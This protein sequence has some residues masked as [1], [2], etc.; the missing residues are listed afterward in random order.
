MW[1]N[2]N[3]R[4]L[5]EAD[6]PQA[7]QQSDYS[8]APGFDVSQQTAYEGTTV[9][10]SEAVTSNTQATV[11]P[12]P[13]PVNQLPQAQSAVQQYQPSNK[14]ILDADRLMVAAAA[15]AEHVFADIV[16]KAEGEDAIDAWPLV[17]PPF[18]EATHELLV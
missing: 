1:R 17:D 10:G 18:Q 8:R 11:L 6:Q 16:Q 2:S 15:Q 9:A 5:R 13:A 4:A 3:T 7:L 12:Q 14:P